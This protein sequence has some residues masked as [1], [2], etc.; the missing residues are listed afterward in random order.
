MPC[1]VSSCPPPAHLPNAE[2]P[3]KRAGSDGCTALGAAHGRLRVS[4]WLMLPLL[5]SF[6]A[7]LSKPRSLRPLPL[8]AAA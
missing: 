3:L 5:L 7:L 6:P 1:E 2:R 8:R 4:P